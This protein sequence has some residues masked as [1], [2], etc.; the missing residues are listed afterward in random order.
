[1]AGRR[2]RVVVGTRERVVGKVGTWMGAREGDEGMV[3]S[4][5]ADQE[6]RKRSDAL[7]AKACGLQANAAAA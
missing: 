3:T 7:L 2:R 5:G 6:A 4:R 1:M